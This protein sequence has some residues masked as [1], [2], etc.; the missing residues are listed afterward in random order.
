MT[1]ASAQV[2]SS[3]GARRV[4]SVRSSRR[5]PSGDSPSR[6]ASIGRSVDTSHTPTPAGDI[7]ATREPPGD[8]AKIG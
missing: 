2:R 1:V 5:N 3:A 7:A 6:G 4:T 8:N